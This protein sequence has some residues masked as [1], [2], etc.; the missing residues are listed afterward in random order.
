MNKPYLDISS[1]L[2]LRNKMGNA[3]YKKLQDMEF[4]L[5]VQQK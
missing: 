5:W 1:W 4:P 3:E 2:N